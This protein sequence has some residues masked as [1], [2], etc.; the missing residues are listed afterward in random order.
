MIILT[1]VYRV[2]KVF[3]KFFGFLLTVSLH[4]GSMLI[5]HLGVEEWVRW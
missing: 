4:R 1:R 3:S 2:N 5:Y